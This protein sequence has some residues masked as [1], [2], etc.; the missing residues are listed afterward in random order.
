[1][2]VSLSLGNPN[3]FKSLYKPLYHPNFRLIFPRSFPNVILLY[4]GDCFEKLPDV[5]QQAKPAA[6]CVHQALDACI[7]A[8]AGLSHSHFRGARAT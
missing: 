3:T 8:I 7:P 1:M 4:W 5:S 6:V 2:N